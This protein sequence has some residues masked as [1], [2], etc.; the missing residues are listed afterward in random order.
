MRTRLE[1]PKDYRIGW[2]AALSIERAAATA[3]LDEHHDPPDKFRQHPR[4]SN[5]YTW[6]RIGKHN[7]V[8]ASLPTGVYGT[9]SAAATAS[10]LLSSLPHIDIGLL[11]GIAGGIARPQTG[12]D[13]R[14]GDVV[15]SQ[16]DGTSGG[17][18]Q[19]DFGK[20]IRGQKWQLSGSLR[21]PPTV[22]LSALSSLQAIH[23]LRPSKVPNLIDEMIQNNPPMGVPRNGNPSFQYQG[24]DNDRLFFSTYVH[25]GGETCEGCDSSHQIRRSQR[26]STAPKIHYGVVGSGNTLVK[27]GVARD[28][29][30]DSVGA[31]I[32]CVEMEAAGVMNHFPCLVVRG[33]CDYADSHKNDRW[34]RYACATAAAFT[35]ELLEYVP[36]RKYF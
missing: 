2:I 6:G 18:I 32:L 5:Y 20:A 26:R 31:R 12:Q 16:P 17:V 11:V 3:F 25:E 10:N 30:V 13:I 28:K 29:L 8:I 7:I 19:Y 21:Q 15:V 24:V 4:D 22:L 34:Q 35:K 36:V 1:N 33:I 9:N 14:L 27:D 23:F